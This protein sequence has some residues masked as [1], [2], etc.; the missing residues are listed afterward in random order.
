MPK[1]LMRFIESTLVCCSDMVNSVIEL[2][3]W[4]TDEIKLTL[5]CSADEVELTLVCCSNMVNSIIESALVFCSDMAN[6]VIE[7]TLVCYAMRLS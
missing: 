5:V 7:L 3:G 6:S 2:T 4:L 1:R